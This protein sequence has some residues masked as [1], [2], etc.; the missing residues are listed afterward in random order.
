MLQHTDENICYLTGGTSYGGDIDSKLYAYN[1]AAQT[2]TDLGAFTYAAE[3]SGTLRLVCA[4]GRGRRDL[5]R[6]GGRY[7]DPVAE[8]NII[9]ADT[10]CY[11]PGA[12][13]HFN[14]PNA[15]LGKLPRAWN[16]GGDALREHDG[17]YEIWG[18]SG[19]DNSTFHLPRRGGPNLH[20]RPVH[21][22]RLLRR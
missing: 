18:I 22:A 19:A 10:Q 21:S 20:L 13:A 5:H 4:L 12:E 1:P 3:S 15:D 9:Y 17:Q 6:R 14:A 8:Q 2:M 16:Q 7:R 11:V